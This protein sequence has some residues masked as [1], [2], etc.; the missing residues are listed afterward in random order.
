[1][2]L[3]V[4]LLS[5]ETKSLTLNDGTVEERVYIDVEFNGGIYRLFFYEIPRQGN[6]ALL[7][8][9][10]NRVD[11]AGM[12]SIDRAKWV[13]ARDITNEEV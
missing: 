7:A 9:I 3:T 5:T 4:K 1:M 12:V 13:F 8:S 10:E 2:A 6:N 11:E